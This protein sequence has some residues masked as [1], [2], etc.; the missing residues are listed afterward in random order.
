[1]STQ[2]ATTSARR[3]GRGVAL[4]AVAAIC[5]WLLAKL[6]PSPGHHAAVIPTLAWSSIYVIVW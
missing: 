6:V 3:R 5:C 4:L 1:M 2:S